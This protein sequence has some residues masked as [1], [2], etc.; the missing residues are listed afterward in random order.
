[1]EKKAY[2]QDD[3]GTFVNSPYNIGQ[4]M[5][6]MQ[7]VYTQAS[8][9]GWPAAFDKVTYDWDN[10]E[11]QDFKD[12]LNFYQEG[13]HQKYKTAQFLSSNHVENGGSFIPV[14][15][16]KAKLPTRAPDMS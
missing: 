8:V 12:W 6:S 14:D 7:A 15:S 5:K 16:L 3:H 10:M 11:K 13:G 2:P 1:M 4:W 9:I